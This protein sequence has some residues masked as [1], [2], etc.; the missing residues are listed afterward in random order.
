MAEKNARLNENTAIIDGMGPKNSRTRAKKASPCAAGK[1]TARRELNVANGDALQ[2]ADVVVHR[3]CASFAMSL[4][5]NPSGMLIGYEVFHV[6]EHLTS[7]PIYGSL[8]SWPPMARVACEGFQKVYED[9]VFNEICIK[10]YAVRYNGMKSKNPAFT[11][12]K[13]L[14]RFI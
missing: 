5:R 13:E 12:N 9:L 3:R 14:H 6:G 1:V 8:K 2:L 11:F 4:L 10:R 7:G